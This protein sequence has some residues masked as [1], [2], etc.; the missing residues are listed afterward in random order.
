MMMLF[1]FFLVQH[2]YQFFCFPYLLVYMFKNHQF[3]VF[4]SLKDILINH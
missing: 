3:C 1:F 2:G 4:S